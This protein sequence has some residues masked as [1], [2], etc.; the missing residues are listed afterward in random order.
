VLSVLSLV[1]LF[2]LELGRES[3]GHA[4]SPD[5]E[6]VDVWSVASLLRAGDAKQ[7]LSGHVARRAGSVC[8]LAARSDWMERCSTARSIPAHFSACERLDNLGTEISCKRNWS[9]VGADL[10][11]AF[12]H[13]RTSDMVLPG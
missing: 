5:K 8:L 11:R 7:A 13:R 12:D 4:G 3:S 1:D 10:A 6:H 9:R 2:L